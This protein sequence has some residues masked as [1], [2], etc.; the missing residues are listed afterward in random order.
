[1]TTGFKFLAAAGADAVEWGGLID[2]LPAACRDIHYLPEYGRVYA[3]THG[4]VPQLAV[5][6]S[7]YGFVIQPFIVRR[8]DDLPFL[9]EGDEH[10]EYRDIANAY[11]Y[12]GPLFYCVA[13]AAPQSL[14]A[15]FNREFVQYCASQRFASEFCS[16]HPLIDV[17]KFLE[18]SGV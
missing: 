10:G 16:L 13:H 2:R 1:M 3:E 8:L 4:V 14:L 15:A 7:D 12:G 18:G 17:A 11:G 6:E 9:K 5:F